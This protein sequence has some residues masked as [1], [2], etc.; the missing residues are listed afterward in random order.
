MGTQADIIALF[1]LLN[2]AKLIDNKSFKHF[3]VLIRDHFEQNMRDTNK[4]IQPFD[5]ENLGTVEDQINIKEK[6][7]RIV[8]VFN[9]SLKNLSEII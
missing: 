1:Y 8:K 2:Q 5:N 4:G 7:E 3:K 6:S 9:D